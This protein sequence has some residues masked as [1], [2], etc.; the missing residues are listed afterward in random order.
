M[1]LYVAL[2]SIV[3]TFPAAATDDEPVK[4]VLKSENAKG[5]PWHPYSGQ[6]F[7]DVREWKVLHGDVEAGKYPEFGADVVVTFESGSTVYPLG[8]SDWVSADPQTG[9]YWPW[10]FVW[11]IY[12]A[13]GWV[14]GKHLTCG[15]YPES[16]EYFRDTTRHGK[17][18]NKW[19]ALDEEGNEVKYVASN[20]TGFP[21][22]TEKPFIKKLER[23]DDTVWKVAFNSTKA[24][25]LTKSSLEGNPDTVISGFDQPAYI[26]DVKANPL[27]G[28]YWLIDYGRCRVYSVSADGTVEVKVTGLTSPMSLEVDEHGSVW[29]N[30]FY[31]DRIVRV[32]AG[33]ALMAGLKGYRANFTALDARDGSLWISETGFDRIDKVSPEGEVVFS[34]TDYKNPGDIWIDPDDGTA[35]I[36]V[37]G[38]NAGE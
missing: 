34:T 14:Y 10:Y 32:S 18:G 30:D 25:E 16:G 27:T 9:E 1:K 15:V 13:R 20:P 38:R 23:G 28:D 11:N 19:I 26:T 22:R 6:V 36:W 35:Y 31:N 33:G 12:N 24:Y 2:L 8:E 5:V 37:S 7:L 4:L 29:I 21:G 3:L 17:S